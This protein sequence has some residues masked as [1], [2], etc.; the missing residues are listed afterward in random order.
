MKRPV[1][2]LL[3]LFISNTLFSQQIKVTRDFGI[4][5]GVNIEKEI[6]KKIE[7]NLEQQLR[8]YSNATQFDDYIID[9]GSKYKIN[10]KFKL[11][12]NIRYTYNAKR[13]KE[14]EN[15]YRYNLDLLYK[16][17]LSNKVSIRYRLRYQKEY[18]NL[19]S[20]YK[21]TNIHSSS[22]RNQIKVQYKADEM[23]KLFISAE[24]YRLIETFKEP[25][26]NLI[27]FHL[28]DNIKTRIGEFNCSVGYA[29]EINTSYPLSFFFLKTIY[30]LKL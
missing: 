24:L 5:G 22:I 11:G 7:V 18:V 3:F 19:L 25:Y 8:F 29:Q 21:R 9:F 4:W 1:I 2:I 16:G 17:K 6:S 14:A 13:W 15:N 28:G 10:K 12:A 20:E 23:N 27:R 26:F 30:T